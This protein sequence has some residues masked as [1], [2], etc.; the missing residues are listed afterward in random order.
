MED[1]Q[2]IL[3]VKRLALENR[4]Q[5]T[6]Q[7][8]V[9]ALSDMRVRPLPS[10]NMVYDNTPV[11]TIGYIP[12]AQTYDPV[13]QAL[14]MARAGVDA[15]ALFTDS[16]VY[17][18]GQ[19]DLLMVALGA[20]NTPVITFDYALNEYHVVE[21]R[22]AG[23]SAIMLYASLVTEATLKK[24]VSIALRVRMTVIIHAE[25]TEQFNL[26]VAMGPHAVSIGVGDYFLPTDEN[27][28]LL[29]HAHANKP[30]HMRLM[31]R[32]CIQSITHMATVVGYGVDAVVLDEPL[33]RDKSRE[34]LYQL[35]G[36]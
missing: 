12:L 25:T 4:Q 28:A 13:L 5:R 16:R 3:S 17:S 10:L 30:Y 35:R 15:V 27:S 21:L 33:V 11:M 8:A 19:Q 24:M 34:K 36:E 1:L 29:A 7:L 6:P 20:K 31:F 9:I 23:A 2:K 26:A 32:P 18:K 22:A 14:R